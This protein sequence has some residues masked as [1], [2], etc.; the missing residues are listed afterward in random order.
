M[1]ACLVLFKLHQ[2]GGHKHI[3]PPKNCNHK[4]NLSVITFFGNVW[5]LHFGLVLFVLSIFDELE[6]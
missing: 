4:Y 3:K 6:T 2:F 5:M 1:L